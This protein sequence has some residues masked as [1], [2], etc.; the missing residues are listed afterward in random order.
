MRWLIRINYEPASTPI[1]RPR[2]YSNLSAAS[3]ARSVATSAVDE[4]ALQLGAV[5]AHDEELLEAQA[6]GNHLRRFKDAERQLTASELKRRRDQQRLGSIKE[7][8][9]N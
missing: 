2:A 7:G 5:V 6:I 4:L 8:C 1:R 3:D 9:L